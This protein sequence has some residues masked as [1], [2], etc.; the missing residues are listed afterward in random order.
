MPMIINASMSPSMTFGQ[1]A[2]AGYSSNIHMSDNAYPATSQ[3]K[4]VRK[5]SWKRSSSVMM[6]WL[7]QRTQKK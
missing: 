6:V 7:R 1:W 2:D 3:W 5:S 4:A